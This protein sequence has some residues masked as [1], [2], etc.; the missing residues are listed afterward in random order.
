[1]KSIRKENNI[2]EKLSN[3][4]KTYYSDS[5]CENSCCDGS[6]YEYCRKCISDTSKEFYLDFR[7]IAPKAD[8]I[9]VV[10][11]NS[12]WN[13]KTG[14]LVVDFNE[15]ALSSILNKTQSCTRKLYRNG[16][17]MCGIGYSHDVPTGSQWVLKPICSK[18]VSNDKLIEKAMSIYN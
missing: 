1:M 14:Y 9:L 12:T 13:H 16:K 15:G 8:K 17:K 2:K 18:G 5:D 7:K 6:S 4:V 3:N 10:A 11:Y